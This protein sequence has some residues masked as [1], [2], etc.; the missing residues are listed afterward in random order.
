[1]NKKAFLSGLIILL[2][3]VGLGAGVYLVQQTQL[4]QQEAAVPDGIVHINITPTTQSVNVG[5]YIDATI[6]INFDSDIETLPSLSSILAEIE[7]NFS[8]TSPTIS[9]SESNIEFLLPNMQQWS[10]PLR[11][12]SVQQNTAR[13]RLHAYNVAHQGFVPSS[14]TTQFARVRFTANQ[15]GTVTL[16]FDPENSYVT[17]KF[18]AQDILMIPSSS[19]TYTV[20][21]EATPPPTQPPTATSTPAPGVPTSTPAPES[22]DPSTIPFAITYPTQNQSISVLQPTFRGTAPAGSVINFELSSGLTGSATSNASGEWSWALTSQLTG[23]SHTLTAT[24]GAQTITRNFTITT[25]TGDTQMPQAGSIKHLSIL[26]GIAFIMI[27]SGLYFRL[28]P[29]L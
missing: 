12:F 18:S 5:D 24:L 26:L 25:A 7:F 10:F 22:T 28:A 6:S 2:L 20:T 29:K 8:G 4:I 15:P 13:V 3:A 17:E 21:G 19:A 16:T 9:T 1:M 27:I 14:Q 11:D 23:G